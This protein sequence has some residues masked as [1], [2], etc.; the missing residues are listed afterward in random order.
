MKVPKANINQ[1]KFTEEE[2]K[3]LYFIEKNL[4]ENKRAM[5]E[6]LLVLD[7]DQLQMLFTLIVRLGD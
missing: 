2:L 1:G 6:K 4:D 7:G 3:L 5:N